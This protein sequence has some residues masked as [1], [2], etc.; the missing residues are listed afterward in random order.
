VAQ[1]GDRAG[2]QADQIDAEVLQS[3]GIAQGLLGAAGEPLALRL[4]RVDGGGPNGYVRGVEGWQVERCFHGG[5]GQGR[6]NAFVLRQAGSGAKGLSV[7]RSLPARSGKQDRHEDHAG[8][9]RQRG[10]G[11]HRVDDCQFDIA[12]NIK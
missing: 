2:L 7:V 1:G 12:M 3:Q 10:N 8:E 4:R 9:N 6:R 5:M 11:Q